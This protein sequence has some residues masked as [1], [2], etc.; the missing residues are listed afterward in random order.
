ML[1]SNHVE[2][3]FARPKVFNFPDRSIGDAFLRRIDDS[4]KIL[5]K[6]I[7]T[8]AD[9]TTLVNEYIKGAT[10]DD[11]PPLKDYITVREDRGEL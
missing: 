9:K 6:D 5:K 4:R 3:L 2:N 11:K 1:S 8:T 10:S 7:Y